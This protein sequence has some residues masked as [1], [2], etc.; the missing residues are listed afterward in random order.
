MFAWLSDRLAARANFHR[1]HHKC[2]R[3]GLYFRREL[4]ACDI[5]SGLSDEQLQRAVKQ[6][7]A[8]R[9]GLGKGMMLGAVLIL[10][11]MLLL[12]SG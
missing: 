6:R 8:F 2:N 4:A 7:K 3:C 9:L 10:L 1:E 11:I 5:C 12:S